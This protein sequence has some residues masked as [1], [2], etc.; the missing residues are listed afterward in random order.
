MKIKALLERKRGEWEE[1]PVQIHPDFPDTG[2]FL[3]KDRKVKVMDI[4]CGLTWGGQFFSKSYRQMID[5]VKINHSMIEKMKTEPK[6]KEWLTQRE[7]TTIDAAKDKNNQDLIDYI[8]RLD[9]SVN[10]CVCCGAIIP[11]GRQVCPK[12]EG[13]K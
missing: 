7:Q 4:T 9:I 13:G 3:D 11:E 8:E 1:I 5:I 6:R 2:M 10:R 12:C